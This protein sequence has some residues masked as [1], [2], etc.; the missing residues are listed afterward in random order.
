VVVNT[1]S[2]TSA[3]DQGARQIIRKIARENP[4]ARIVVTGCYATRQ[5]AELARCRRG[6]G[7]RE[8]SQGFFS[9]EE[10]LTTAERFQR[11]RRAR[12]ARNVVPA[13]RAA[14]RTRFEC[15]P[16]ATKLRLLHHSFH[17][18]PRQKPACRFV[19]SEI[20]ARVRRRLS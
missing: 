7:D 4:A 12:A 14:P 1:C 8:R 16:A 10:R 6:A 5:P 15:R 2:V 18:G 20:R 9:A 11:R 17:A 3:S 13:R 19:L